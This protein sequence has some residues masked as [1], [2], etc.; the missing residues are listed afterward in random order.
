MNQQKQKEFH[1]KLDEAELKVREE[2]CE[3]Q[4]KINLIKQSEKGIESELGQLHKDAKNIMEDDVLKS[5]RCDLIVLEGNVTW[6]QNGVP[7]FFK[8][9]RNI[10]DNKS[11]F[12]TRYYDEVMGFLLIKDEN[13]RSD[14]LKSIMILY[15]GEELFSEISSNIKEAYRFENTGS[16]IIVD[17]V[18][19]SY[20]EAFVRECEKPRIGT[21]LQQCYYFKSTL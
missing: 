5:M 16:E 19:F 7:L 14:I 18:K 9:C 21:I 15:I 11:F 10:V 12:I 1:S 2:I 4:E 8:L 17:E 13:E 6:R 20:S 3:M